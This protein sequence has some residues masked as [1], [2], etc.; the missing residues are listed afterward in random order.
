MFSRCLNTKFTYLT[1]V[2]ITLAVVVVLVHIRNL[3]AS[4]MCVNTNA[5]PLNETVGNS[6]AEDTANFLDVAIDQ[7]IN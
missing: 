1:A 2:S 6:L 4:S 7:S 5:A 3:H